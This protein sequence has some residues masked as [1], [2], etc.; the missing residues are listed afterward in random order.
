LCEDIKN[1]QYAEDLWI[2]LFN[3]ETDGDYPF[4]NIAGF[5]LK[6]LSLPH[7]SVDCE[8]VFSKVNLIK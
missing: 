2:S 3:F 7:F 8:R 4:K 5:V 6:V 1:I